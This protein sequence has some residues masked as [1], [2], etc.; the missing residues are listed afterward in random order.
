MSS[1][2]WETHPCFLLIIWRKFS[3]FARLNIK[4]IV[5]YLA[6]LMDIFKRFKF[7]FPG[8]GHHI[9]FG[10]GSI[11]NFPGLAKGRRKSAIISYLY[12]LGRGA[13]KGFKP[14]PV[15]NQT[16]SDPVED[17]DARKTLPCP[18]AR[19]CKFYS[20]WKVSAG[21]ERKESLTV[22]I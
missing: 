19:P 20:Y 8:R 14:W 9:S 22:D 16:S 2:F 4:F 11:P 6:S 17:R 10:I 5:S 21:Q 12:F 18:A 1:G 3:Y 15:P 7:F 13:A